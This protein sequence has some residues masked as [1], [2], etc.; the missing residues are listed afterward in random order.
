MVGNLARNHAEAEQWDLL[1]WQRQ[2]PQERLAAAMSIHEDIRKIRR[3]S[4]S[5]RRRGK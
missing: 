4:P 5:A 2:T 1:F 3:R